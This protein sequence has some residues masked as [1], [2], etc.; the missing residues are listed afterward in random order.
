MDPQTSQQPE[1]THHQS[2]IESQDVIKLQTTPNNSKKMLLITAVFIVLVIVIG[3]IV[4]ILMNRPEQISSPQNILPSQLPN[5]Y[6]K[7]PVAWANDAYSGKIGSPIEFTAR[8]SYDPSGIPISLYEW[9]FD[10]DGTFEFQTKNESVTHI[11]EQAYAG[12]IYL[13]VTG[14]H[15]TATSRAYV[16]VN[17]LGYTSQGDEEPCPLDE[18]GYSI[19][20]DENGVFMN[21]TATNLPTE[22]ME[23]IQIILE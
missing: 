10:G 19:I 13:R 15:G 16:D 7:Q 17:E 6:S 4:L 12:S 9:D 1:L 22:D 14:V 21:C 20:L 18:N 8:G 5:E 3:S 11:Y 2:E 23:G